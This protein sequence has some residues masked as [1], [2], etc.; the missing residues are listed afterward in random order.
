MNLGEIK[1]QIY[2]ISDYKPSNPNYEREVEDLINSN[3]MSIWNSR[4]WTFANKQIY[5][6]VFPDITPERAAGEVGSTDLPYLIPVKVTSQSPLTLAPTTGSI[7]A[8]FTQPVNRLVSHQSAYIGNPIEVMG[9][10][11]TIVHIEYFG[12]TI[13]TSGA[14][15]QDIYARIYVDKPFHFT[16]EGTTDWTIKQRYHFLPD[17]LSETIAFS[18]RPWPLTGASAAWQALRPIDLFRDVRTNINVLGQQE[19]SNDA[20]A[21]IRETDQT[22]PAG[23]RISSSV[24]TVGATGDFAAGDT[25]EVAWAYVGPGGRVG[26]LGEITKLT[27]PTGT[28]S[29]TCYFSLNLLHMD[30]SEA[31][32]KAYQQPESYGR[33]D[34]NLMYSKQVFYNA[35]W[36]WTAKKRLGPPKWIPITFAAASSAATYG[37]SA[38]PT[39]YQRWIGTSNFVDWEL[40]GRKDISTLT[41]RLKSQ[42]RQI[43]AVGQRHKFASKY[44]RIRLFPRPDSWDAELEAIGTPDFPNATS[45]TISLPLDY[46]QRLTLTYRY[47]PQ[48]LAFQTDAPELPL[49]FHNLVVWATLRDIYLKNSNI[50]MSQLYDQKYE[51]GLR[52][53]AK[54][55][56]TYTDAMTT[57]GGQNT[58]PKYPAY[59]VTYNPNT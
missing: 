38:T 57:K 54:R 15:T 3:Y 44:E 19:T 59:R 4:P 26:P 20:Y 24:I 27:V 58:F 40:V 9:V 48:P 49:E 52:D 32:S 5:F 7:S 46:V 34:E 51:R 36:D 22:I 39:V 1:Q 50:S 13:V 2:S 35:N 45:G 17:D 12:G 10:E 21:Y 30:G 56:I 8:I 23:G 42:L 14:G 6:D 16:E 41:I 18:Y 25:F 28:V 43:T 47:I 37:P 33:P 31:Y 29:T 55:H 11:Y 53:L